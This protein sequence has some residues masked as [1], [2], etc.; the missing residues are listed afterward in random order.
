MYC[1][2]YVKLSYIQIETYHDLRMF[3]RPAFG[4]PYN[5]VNSHKNNNNGDLF[6]LIEVPPSLSKFPIENL[7][8]CL[9]LP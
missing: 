3:T 2:Q 9:L 1:V 5:G 8:G 4:K 7:N 6:S